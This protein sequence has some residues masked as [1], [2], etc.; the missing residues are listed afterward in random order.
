MWYKSNQ[1]VFRSQNE[2]LSV[3]TTYIV[4]ESDHSF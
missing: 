2:L 1:M 3:K 4:I